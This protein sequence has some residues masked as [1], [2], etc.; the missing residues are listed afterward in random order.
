MKV[1]THPEKPTECNT[2]GGK[3]SGCVGTCL[4]V[5]GRK[6]TT[7][8][9]AGFCPKHPPNGDALLTEIYH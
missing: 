3:A 7:K 8:T 6:V 5:K 9:W 4:S 2:C 1:T